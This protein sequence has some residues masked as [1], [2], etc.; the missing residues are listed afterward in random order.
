LFGVLYAAYFD[1]DFY[2]EF[3]AGNE[4]ELSSTKRELNVT[5]ST[6]S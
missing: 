2:N 1:R 6:T 3:Y 5:K 4:K